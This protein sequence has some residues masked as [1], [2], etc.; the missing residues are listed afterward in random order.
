MPFQLAACAE[1]LW[2]DKPIH[3]RAARLHEMGCGVELWNWPDWDLDA[4]EKTGATFTI[5]NGYLEGRLADAE[6]ADMLLASARETAQVGKRLGVHRLNLHG[7]GIGDQGIPVP[8]MAH[9]APGM[10]LRARD[11]LHGICDMAEEVGVTFTLEYLTLREH[12]CCPFN[13]TADVLSLVAAV[14]RPQLRINLDLCHTQIGEGDVIRHAEAS[15]P[16]IGEK[17]VADNPGRYG[18]GTGEM[19]WPMITRALADMGYDC[20]VG[21]ESFAKDYR[22][23]ALAAFRLA[24]TVQRMERIVIIGAGECGVRAA[25]ALREQGFAGTITLLGDEPSLPYERPPLSKGMDGALKPI[26]PEAAYAE[27]GIHHHRGNRVERIDPAAHSVFL[28]SSESLSYDTLLIATGSRARLFPTM[29]GCLTL[30]TDADAAAIFQSVKPGA[31]LG[32]IGGGFI[33][34]ELAAVAR[35]CGADVTVFEAGQRLLARAVP[36]E[37]V[38]IVATRHQAESV[39][40]RTGVGVAAATGTAVLLSGGKTQTFDRV[41]AG[42]GSVPNTELAEAAGLDTGS[43]IHVDDNFRTS[44]PHILAADDCCNFDWRGAG[45]VGKL[46]G[47]AGPGRLCRLCDAGQSQQL[48]SRAVVLVRPVRPNPAGC[49]ALRSR[50]GCDRE[51]DRRRSVHRLPMRRTGAAAGCGGHR[52]GQQHR[53]RHSDIPE[54]HRAGRTA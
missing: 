12:S 42:V 14:D 17:Q 7:T 35:G 31:T 38:R 3:W 24:F 45:L 19:N 16:W 27:A 22:E 20:P 53:Q 48:Q 46:E 52:T 36:A 23:D 41:V 34:L 54:T 50:T 6:R 2:Q 32:I 51:A 8:Q 39:T 21:M 4:L 29:E 33:G 5:M 44:D 28:P 40:I 9:V 47:G 25:F 11:T 37:V 15:L 30:R 13:S 43:G 1:M 10:W 26:R 49:M 18:P